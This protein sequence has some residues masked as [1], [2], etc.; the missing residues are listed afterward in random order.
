MSDIVEFSNGTCLKESSVVELA[1]HISL[2]RAAEI[3][4]V[5]YLEFQDKAS[6]LYELGRQK[7]S[8][9]PSKGELQEENEYLRKKIRAAQRALNGGGG[10]D[11]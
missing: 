6:G 11:E 1:R 3:I 10:D 9:P 5:S 4:G 2:R 8:D 7:S